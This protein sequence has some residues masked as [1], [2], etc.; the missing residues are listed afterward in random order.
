MTFN[1]QLANSYF[2]SWQC[3]LVLLKDT[4]AI[5]CTGILYWTE[6]ID[7][8]W[9]FECHSFGCSDSLSYSIIQLLRSQNKGHHHKID[10]I[11]HATTLTWFLDSSPYIPFWGKAGNISYCYCLMAIQHRS[12]CRNRLTALSSGQSTHDSGIL[13]STRQIWHDGLHQNPCT[14]HIRYRN[15]S[16]TTDTFNILLKNWEV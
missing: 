4:S 16:Q 6:L 7:D 3:F 14:Q 2:F 11:I 1:D 8:L 10:H 9:N 13:L 15:G 5:R 12:P